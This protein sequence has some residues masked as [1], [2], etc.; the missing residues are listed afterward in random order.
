MS[1][2]INE[3]YENAKLAR[4]QALVGNYEMSTVYYQGVVQQIHR[5][6]ATIG[7]PIRKQRWQVVIF[8]NCNNFI[9][10]VLI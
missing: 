4:E 3:I 9:R 6:L 5:L 2:Q 10:R 8:N 1:V 7:D